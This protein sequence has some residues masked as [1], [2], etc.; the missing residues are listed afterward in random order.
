MLYVDPKVFEL[1]YNFG[2]G[3]L[4]NGNPSRC[5]KLETH[6]SPHVLIYYK[7]T[8]LSEEF[9]MDKRART[10]IRVKKICRGV[11]EVEYHSESGVERVEGTAI[12]DAG[13]DANALLLFFWLKF[14]S[15][16]QIE[17][18]N[19]W[20]LWQWLV[21]AASVRRAVCYAHGLGLDS[22]HGPRTESD[23]KLSYQTPRTTD[24][25]RHHR[26][27]LGLR[28]FT[29][30]RVRRK[31]TDHGPSPTSNRHYQTLGPRT[32]SVV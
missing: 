28:L 26:Q 20:L 5:N 24:R 22:D 27:I 7:I 18:L 2:L 1:I 16:S 32:E 21:A 25:V 13:T 4:Q 15:K 11:D 6:A 14:K 19:L 9:V 10:L 17:Q 29:T 8:C 30:D 23:I 12:A 31:I 3:M